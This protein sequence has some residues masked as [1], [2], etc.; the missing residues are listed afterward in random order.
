IP[1][2][3]PFLSASPVLLEGEE[4]DITCTSSKARPTPR[5]KLFVEKSE[6]DTNVSSEFD[7]KT[8]FNLFK[9]VLKL[10]TFQKEWG[11]KKMWCQ[12]LPDVDNLYT[13][14][15]M[16]NILHPPSRLNLN[17]IDQGNP[18]KE[19]AVRCSALDSYPGCN[20]AWESSIENFK[21]SLHQ[22]FTF[23]HTSIS[24][25][26]FNVTDA[27]F[28]KQITCWTECPDFL[29][30]LSN[31][32]SVKFAKMPKIVV[33]SSSVLPVPTNTHLALT[34]AANA[35]PYGNITWSTTL[36]SNEKLC[37]DSSTCTYEMTTSDVEQEY[38]CI[39]ENKHGSD[40]GSIIVTIDKGEPRQ[41]GRGSFLWILLS[42][43]IVV[44]LGIIVLVVCVFRK[45]WCRGN[46]LYEDVNIRQDGNHTYQDIAV[47]SPN[48][49]HEV[50]AT[51]SPGIYNEIDENIP[52]TV[53]A[54][55]NLTTSATE[56]RQCLI[57]SSN[58]YSNISQRIPTGSQV[59]EMTRYFSE[60]NNPGS[61]MGDSNS[62]GGE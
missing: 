9:S 28:G 61:V 47:P 30:S 15:Y 60:S 42:G 7:N 6:I 24:T 21:Y 40:R 8:G 55:T 38:L 22:Y 45:R 27:D 23:K 13:N 57:E 41:S 59:T 5:L 34:C 17:I 58:P 26:H 37:F 14:T 39:A 10:H 44:A 1:E 33:Y 18:S 46:T 49:P 20:I 62:E 54:G 29:N 52:S 51:L 48:R 4:V 3:P 31:S 32:T 2:G 16:S 12:Q 19:L 43:I 35:F 53:Q 11:N 25:I 50:D 56:N 36:L